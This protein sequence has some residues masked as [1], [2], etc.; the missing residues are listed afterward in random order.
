MWQ[1]FLETIPEKKKELTRLQGKNLVLK[2]KTKVILFL[3]KMFFQLFEIQ[4]K[5]EYCSDSLKNHV[6]T[7]KVVNDTAKKGI[8]L[9][10][11]ANRKRKNTRND[12]CWE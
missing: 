4:D 2:E 9:K 8:A 3:M 12:S 1:K 10:K 6:S 7:P 5:T 11:L